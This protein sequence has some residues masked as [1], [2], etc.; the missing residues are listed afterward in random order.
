MFQWSRQY[1][2][3]NAAKAW[4]AAGGSTDDSDIE[5]L[6]QQLVS[7]SVQSTISFLKKSKT[8]KSSRRSV[9]YPSNLGKCP[10]QLALQRAGNPVQDLELPFRVKL[11]IGNVTEAVLCTLFD[12]VGRDTNQYRICGAQQKVT[13]LVWSKKNE[14]YEVLSGRIDRLFYWEDKCFILEMKSTRERSFY[15]ILK[16]GPNNNWGYETQVGSY[17]LALRQSNFTVD[18]VYLVTVCPSSGEWCEHLGILESTDDIKEQAQSVVD[19][20]DAAEEGAIVPR[21]AWATS[22]FHPRVKN[23]D[24]TKGTRRLED[25]RCQYCPVVASCWPGIRYKW[26]SGEKI[27]EFPAES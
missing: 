5:I 12:K 25:L 11:M 27:W 13:P 24:G 10:R 16:E 21:P 1:I 18:G 22:K 26:S 2:L 20:V 9:L 17:V 8:D 14:K 4:M 23:E 3:E 7:D 6:S 19:A 15:G